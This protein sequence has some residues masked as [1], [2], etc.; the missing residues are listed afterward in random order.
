MDD[1]KFDPTL[2][3]AEEENA[4]E[5]VVVEENTAE[6]VEETTEEVAA[7]TVEET[8]EEVAEETAE[9]T[10]VEAVV[11]EEK[12]KKK[13][14]VGKI[15]LL[16][17]LG[18]ILAAVVAL[19]A[20]Y[21]AKM[22]IDADKTVLSVGDVDSNVGEFINVYG[23]YS[24]YASYYG[25]S[26]DE[27]KGYTIDELVAVNT[28]YS[29]AVAEGMTLS[30]EEKAE[31]EA[32]IAS[33][34]AN[35]EASS[36]TADEYLEENLCK[37]YT[38]DAY[39]FYLEKQYLAQ[40][41]YA[42]AMEA[43]NA[44]YA[45]G[46]GADEVQKQ[47]ESDNVSY[48]LSD[49]SYWYFDSTDENAKTL[50][51]AVVEKVKDGTDFAKAVAEVTG[52]ADAQPKSI[53]GKAKSVISSNFS[54]SAA[55]WIF[56]IKDGEYVNGAG[57]VTALEEDKLVYVIYVNNAPS[58]DESIPVTVD[59]V[60]V[61]VGTDLTVKSEDELRLEAKATATSILA[62]FESGNKTADD[63][64]MLKTAY[65]NKD[66]LVT[67][68]VFSEITPD[69]SGYEQ[70]DEWVF[71]AERKVGDYALV[72]G[73]DCYFILFYTSVNNYEVWYQTALNV[74]LESKYQDWDE[75]VN[76]EFEDKTVINDDVIA[77]VLEYLALV[78]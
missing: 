35:A 69:A 19:F 77:E 46:K 45:D 59:Y 15:I 68:D 63:F 61:D 38:M 33:I 1:N 3:N 9:E 16:S 65:T 70:V 28:Y 30:E 14:K 11:T 21:S 76:A 40:K 5:D 2:G 62:D 34:T 49:V 26:E 22:N 10:E 42:Q 18:V 41:Y 17:I 31:L 29:K 32:N 67:P 51:D 12:P 37:G 58:R 8:T 73:D 50:A 52:D 13:K 60:R 27:V 64:A 53:K 7:E 56:E 78:G 43:I 54:T 47:Y 66:S 44:D 57:A 24:Y 23:A 39:R 48:D 75:Q 55:D 71:N 72:E 36:M 4:A 20:V 6:T 25:F 74:I